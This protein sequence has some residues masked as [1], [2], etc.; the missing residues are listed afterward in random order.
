MVKG[1]VLGSSA[2]WEKGIDRVEW[3]LVDMLG[4]ELE[5]EDWKVG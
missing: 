3:L 2:R 4:S 5:F 1:G